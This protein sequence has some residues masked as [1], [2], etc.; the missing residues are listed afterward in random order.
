MT[1]RELI[2]DRPIITSMLDED[3]YNFHMGDFFFHRYF[4][5]IARYG[6]TCRDFG[7]DF[8]PIYEDIKQQMVFLGELR[9]T[10][11]ECDWLLANSYCSEQ[12]V[13]SLYNN[14]ILDPKNVDMKLYGNGSMDIK[15]GGK[16]AYE[17]LREV[18]LLP[19][20]SELHFRHLYRDNY[21]EVVAS[22]QEWIENEIKWLVEN[23]HPAFRFFEAGGRRR[24]SFDRHEQVLTGLWN[25]LP[26]DD[27]GKPKFI[28]GTSN[29]LMGMKHNI[30]TFGTQA[31]QLYMFMQTVTHPAHSM[32]R[33][34]DEWLEHY[35]GKLAI[36]L[37]DTLGNAK[38]D[39]DFVKKYQEAFDGQRH[40]SGPEHSWGELRI[41]AYN[42]DM[43]DPMTK[44]FVFGNS[45]TPVTGNK[46][47]EMFHG[48]IGSVECLM[49]T[50][51][52]N[53]LGHRFPNHKALSQ[54]AKMM[55][56]SPF[57]GSPLLPC[58]KL[59]ADIDSAK[60]QCEDMNHLIYLKT[61][62]QNY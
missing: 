13:E 54:V 61:V 24:F 39:R 53:S 23:A 17:I 20:V 57:P 42:R 15:Y 22:T 32:T 60:N 48:R 26:K 14:P 29:C 59:G 50:Y 35:N 41:D 62:A 58:G 56:A 12:Y 11:A 3:K 16:T 7:I 27:A 40:D 47:T 33:G 25:G 6:Y 45:L 8:A 37:S 31:H 9:M 38:W 21:D 10:S 2:M 49:G 46:Y 52:T 51:W 44:K 1:T 5:S 18:K 4:D 30:P 55:W 43:V 19:I 28:M 36:A 34:M